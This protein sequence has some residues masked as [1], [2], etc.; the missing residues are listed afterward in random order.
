MRTLWIDC[1]TRSR[2]ELKGSGVHRYAEDVE[3]TVTAWAVN[4]GPVHVGEGI[5]DAFLEE[6][7]RCDLGIAHNAEFDRTVLSTVHPWLGLDFPWYCTMAQARRHGLPGGLDKICEVL[8]IRDGLA[9]HKEGRALIMLFCKPRP[10]GT[11]ADKTTHPAEWARFLAYAGSDI[12]AMREAHRLLPKW[13]DAV[14]E[15]HYR[16]DQII[17]A[18]GFAVDVPFARTVVDTLKD[19]KITLDR[20]TNEATNGAV[21]AATQRDK[22]LAHLLAE[23]GVDLPDMQAATLERRIADPDLPD[24]VRELLSIRL[25]SSKTSTGKYAALLKGVCS[26]GRMRGTLAYGG[27]ARTLRWAGQRFQPHNLPRLSGGMTPERVEFGIEALKAGVADIACEVSVPEIAAFAVRG[28]VVAPEGKKLIVDDYS[29]IE[30]RTLPFLAGERWKLD[31]FRAYD[32]DPENQPDLYKVAY[33][34]AFGMKPQDVNKEQRQ[35]GKVMELMLGFGGGVGA[36]LTGAHTYRIDLDRM[37]DLALPGIAPAVLRECEDAWRWAVEQKRTYDLTQHTYMACDGLKRLWRRAHP[38][39]EVFWRDLEE[40]CQNVILND[41]Y[42]FL[43]GRI[44]VDRKGNWLRLRLPSGRYLCYPSP[45]YDG[46]GLSYMG[47]NQYTKQWSRIK[48]Y[49]GKLSENVTQAVARDV[50]A[51]GILRCEEEGDLPVVLHVHDEVVSEVDEHDDTALARHA[52]CLTNMPAWADGLPLAVAGFE[53]KR[54]RK[55]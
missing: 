29:A 39:I 31:A 38:K 30:G 5:P 15:A 21:T 20:R 13:N 17:N 41:T 28:C 3:V 16:A 33:G 9:K 54:Y 4:D 32:A 10:D 45:R 1:E 8:R 48:T 6:A 26:D 40:A 36:F 23:H 43:V 22:L 51:Q 18:R 14:E 42:D 19:T 27:A 49:G 37:A 35:I 55:E 50:L 34:R 46:G 2:I 47:Q 52:A 44:V 7:A 11:W 25:Q 12:S 24:L 53:T